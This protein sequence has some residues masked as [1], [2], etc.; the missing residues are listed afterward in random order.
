MVA[1]SK[2]PL[3]IPGVRSRRPWELVKSKYNK[4]L[5]LG[6]HDKAHR[7]L[8]AYTKAN[9]DDPRGWETLAALQRQ[10]NDY[11]GA[12]RASRNALELEPGSVDN[13]WM[14]AIA[15]ATQGRE[16][17]ARVLFHEF[18]NS[19][20]DWLGY[21]GRAWLAGDSRDVVE[22]RANAR[23]M[24]ASLPEGEERWLQDLGAIVLGLPGEH[25][26][27]EELL[28][29]GLQSDPQAAAMVMLALLLEERGAPDAA[30]MMERARSHWPASSMYL[31]RTLVA[32]RKQLRQT[33][34][35]E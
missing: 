30:A 21:L 27:A 4:L 24:E 23:R 17:E 14:L 26:W 12:E 22:L 33:R 15:V 1:A 3:K 35:Q 11:A 18:F 25:E 6:L 16:V 2:R 8:V 7:L 19:G 10:L 29:K 13:L 31:E 9:P 20:R 34:S 32:L 5:K 28:R